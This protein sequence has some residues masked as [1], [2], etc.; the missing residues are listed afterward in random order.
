[1]ELAALRRVAWTLEGGER[2]DELVPVDEVELLVEAVLKLHHDPGTNP[3]SGRKAT[4]LVHLAVGTPRLGPG[5]WWSGPSLQDD[6]PQA[7]LVAWDEETRFTD[8]QVVA[9]DPA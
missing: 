8:G 5:Y 6:A 1:M 2:R 9:R 7:Q 3:H 4:P